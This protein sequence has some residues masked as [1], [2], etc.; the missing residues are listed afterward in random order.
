[1]TEIKR[2]S[3][4]PI[5]LAE[6]AH[7]IL[8]GFSPLLVEKS[9]TRSERLRCIRCNLA[10]EMDTTKRYFRIVMLPKALSGEF[11]Q[12]WMMLAD[13]KVYIKD[14]YNHKTGTAP[15]EETPLVQQVTVNA[16]TPEPAAYAETE[17]TIVKP[18]PEA[19]V[20][21]D[22]NSELRA[23]ILQSNE[24]SPSLKP[25]N[26]TPAKKE[27]EVETVLPPRWVEVETV[28]ANQRSE[29]I[30]SFLKIMDQ[31]GMGLAYSSPINACY[32]TTPH[33]LVSLAHQDQ[34]CIPGQ[35]A[36]CPVMA[37]GFEGP[38]PPELR[39]KRKSRFNLLKIWHAISPFAPFAVVLLVI[40]AM[41]YVLV[42]AGA[43]SPYAFP[44]PLAYLYTHPWTA[45]PAT[46]TPNLALE[47]ADTQVPTAPPPG[48]T[49]SQDIILGPQDQYTVHVVLE[50]E[51][52]VSLEKT[53]HMTPEAIA[54]INPALAN[55]ELEPLMVLV[56]LP[57]RQNTDNLV[58][59]KAARI[60]EQTSLTDL[61]IG[62]HLNEDVFREYN[63]VSGN[64]LAPGKWI[65]VPFAANLTIPPTPTLTPKPSA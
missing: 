47:L 49:G 58:P 31:P 11:D 50:G 62:Y 24:V 1:M 48:S 33:C 51:T 3:I 23:S 7:C 55:G 16:S 54:K 28:P 6:K 13:L 60:L 22:I 45:P 32:K 15:I 29:W 17:R 10:L 46:P 27:I 53:Y 39:G 64:Q 41:G 4:I 14:L 34:F 20:S 42:L 19:V 44:Q 56:M 38:L 12:N 52:M 36:L 57:G 30:C 65:I 21:D 8:C 37:P 5:S 25:A 26:V 43:I 18:A 35:S 2:S 59:L 63:R 61:L 9:E 40:I